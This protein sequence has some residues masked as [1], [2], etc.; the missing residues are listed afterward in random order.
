M[1]VPVNRGERQRHNMQLRSP[2][3]G[4]SLTEL[5]VVFT[6]VALLIGGAM[7]TLS[8]Q[9]EERNYSE[10]NRRLS[11]AA[12]ALVAFA[13]VNK[14]LPCPARFTSSASHSAGQESFCA[15]G[16][17]TSCVGS[18]ITAFQAHGNCSNFY[19]GYVPAVAIG[20][21]PVDDSGFL[22]DAWSNRLRYVVA[23]EKTGCT[24]PGPGTNR[25]F[26]AQD[27]MKAYGVGC[28]PNDLEVCTTN[29][30]ATRVVSVETVVFIV[31]STGKN[32]STGSY[33]ADETENTD[34]D[35]RFVSRTPSPADS[36]L[37][38]Y[39]DIVVPVPVGIVYSKLLT[40]GVLP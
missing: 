29:S 32:G 21:S 10:T 5:A 7:M 33:G 38:A 9:I 1:P 39:D 19:N 18:E 28:R 26:T 6:I 8:A 16:T 37:G 25:V 13:V 30:C 20:A 36:A 17:A 35:V 34:G 40:A 22:V 2:Q 15:S 12:E 24:A 4:F 27:N 23:R 11:A 31:Y 14:R 3:R